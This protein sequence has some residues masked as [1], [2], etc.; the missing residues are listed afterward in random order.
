M[1][2]VSPKLAAA[3]ER[4][5]RYFP[6]RAKQSSRIASPSLPQH[7]ALAEL[8]SRAAVLSPRV[9]QG[10]GSSGARLAAPA[11]TASLLHHPSGG[12]DGNPNLWNISVIRDEAELQVWNPNLNLFPNWR[13]GDLFQRFIETKSHEV[14]IW[15]RKLRRV[16]SLAFGLGPVPNHSWL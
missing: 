13:T 3:A 4:K 11:G 12:T 8:V 6:Y 5:K 1:Y 14:L 2:A 7:G 15:I 16:Q 10:R 9:T